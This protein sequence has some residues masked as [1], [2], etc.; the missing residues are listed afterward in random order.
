MIK[1][2]LGEC[3]IVNMNVGLVQAQEVKNI[4]ALKMVIE[5]NT[6]NYYPIPVVKKT[7]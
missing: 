5:S 4:E 1:T 7:M 3:N 2:Y 6:T